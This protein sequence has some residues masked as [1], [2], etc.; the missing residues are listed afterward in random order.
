MQECYCISLSTKCSRRYRESNPIPEVQKRYTG[1]TMKENELNIDIIVFRIHE[2]FTVI[3]LMR[4]RNAHFSQ[5][6]RLMD[7]L[8]AY[9]S[10]GYITMTDVQNRIF[11]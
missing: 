5:L 9:V 4:L 3:Q 2:D 10:T 11:S 1:N 6:K 7:G 8:Y